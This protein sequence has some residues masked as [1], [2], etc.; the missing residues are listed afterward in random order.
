MDI[1]NGAQAARVVL[2]IWIVSPL[3]TNLMI[4]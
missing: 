1:R 4:E 2:I 3:R